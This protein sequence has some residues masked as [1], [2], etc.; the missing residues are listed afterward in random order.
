MGLFS[1]FRNMFSGEDEDE[2]EL[3]AARARHGIVVDERPELKNK[4]EAERFAENYDVWEDIDRYRSTFFFGGYLA[5]KFRPVGEEKV[6]K[7][8]AELEQKRL[9]DEAKKKLEGEGEK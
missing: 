7:Q 9:A 3:D 8:L 1:F 2:R 5:K 6:R 4:P